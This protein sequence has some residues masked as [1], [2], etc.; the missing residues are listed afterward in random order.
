MGGSAL[1]EGYNEPDYTASNTLIN[2]YRSGGTQTNTSRYKT[3]EK[4]L[5]SKMTNRP[6]I[7]IPGTQDC[8]NPNTNTISKDR[9]MSPS[10]TYKN[11][12]DYRKQVLKRGTLA[13]VG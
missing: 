9:F 12:L 6:S 2:D 7:D 8:T 1:K 13:R 3:F 11:C 5:K 4:S 10:P